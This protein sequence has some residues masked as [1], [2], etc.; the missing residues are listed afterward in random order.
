MPRRCRLRTAQSDLGG[1]IGSGGLQGIMARTRRKTAELT[2]LLAVVADPLYVLD[3]QQRLIYCSAALERWTGCTSE[4]LIGQTCRYHTPPDAGRAETIVAA[5]CPPPGALAG[6]I[7]SF[8]VSVPCDDG[9]CETRAARCLPLMGHDVAAAGLIVLLSHSD[10]QPML[11]TEDEIDPA[12]LHAQLQRFRAEHAGPFALDQLIGQSAAMRRVRG[13]LDLAAR[14]E[15]N[16][17]LVG[18][19]GTGRQHL[20]KAIHYGRQP[21]DAGP[22]VPLSCKLLGG[23]LLRSTLSALIKADAASPAGKRRGT[24]LLNDVDRLPT[25]AQ[26]DL[27]HLLVERPFP[28]RVVATSEQSPLELAARG[29]FPAEL[30]HALSTLVIPLPTLAER[31]DDLPLLAQAFVEAFNAES[32]K[33][34]A[35]LTPE[36]LERLAAYPWPGQL[37]ELAAVIRESCQQAAGQ[38]VTQRDLPQRITRFEFARMAP[39]DEPIVLDELLSEIEMRLIVDALARAK[40]NKTKA[41]QFLGVTRPRLYRRLVQLGLAEDDNGEP[42]DL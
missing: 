26:A 31:M 27:V 1:G 8:T 21:V 40:G 32:S 24:L 33:Q 17:V 28:L 3:E 16:V 7:H 12:A 30:G 22:L 20:A 19:K 34:L 37:D 11:P 4:E 42:A 15:A 35:G 13:Q 18:S 6:K 41:A 29:A 39:R 25:D 2:R 5:L 10:A 14:S 9:R 36:A 23:D 38:V